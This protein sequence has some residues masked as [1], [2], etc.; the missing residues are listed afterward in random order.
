MGKL[1]LKWQK[2]SSI[3]DLKKSLYT[4]FLY[5]YLLK[6]IYPKI[7]LSFK[8]KVLPFFLNSSN[9][10]KGMVNPLPS[11]SAEVGLFG[12]GKTDIELFFVAIF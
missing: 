3:K 6:L 12:P 5:Y 1:I 10:A 8:I 11:L 4:L 7:S 2:K 9:H